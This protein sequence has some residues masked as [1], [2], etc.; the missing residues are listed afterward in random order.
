M[1]DSAGSF[2]FLHFVLSSP[3]HRQ[4]AILQKNKQV[5]RQVCNILLNIL[6]KHIPVHVTIINNL[7]QYRSV[8][9][10]LVDRRVSDF[11]KKQ[12]ILQNPAILK[13]IVPLLKDISKS[14]RYEPLC[15]DVS[16]NRKR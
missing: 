10:K 6:L 15:E 13:L 4:I 5:V 11:T 2:R 1:C 9:Y 3:P 8:I 16:D 7:R 14:F 12:L